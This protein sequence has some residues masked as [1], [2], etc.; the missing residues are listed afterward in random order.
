FQSIPY[1][2]NDLMH[3][4]IVLFP[5]LSGEVYGASV[6]K[7]RK[8]DERIEIGKKLASIL[9]HKRLLNEFIRFAKLTTHTGSRNDY[10]QYF[11]KNMRRKTPCL[12]LTFPIINHSLP[13]T[14]PWD[15]TTKIKQKWFK[16]VSLNDPEPITNWYKKKQKEK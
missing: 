10:E 14:V 1:K 9:F 4:S 11:E 5:T 3:Y 8:L 7:F 2:L 15:E 12:R 6:K 16:E 13:N